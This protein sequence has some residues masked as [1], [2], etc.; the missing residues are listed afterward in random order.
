MKKKINISAAESQV[1]E[2]L[3]RKSPLTPEE[4]IAATAKPNGWGAG[5]V[6]T[7][8]TRLLRKGALAGTRRE[9]NYFYHPLITRADYVQSES[10]MLLDRL[11]Q[12]QVA[13]FVAHFATQRAL[14]AADLKKLKKLI[15]ELEDDNG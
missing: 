4:I 6:R 8:I 2:A 13:P 15:E 11:F 1:M 9:G 7:L 5:T 10:Q 14:T 3:W 12:G